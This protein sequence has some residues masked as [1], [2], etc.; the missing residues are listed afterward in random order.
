[1][2]LKAKKPSLA[3]KASMLYLQGPDAGQVQFTIQCNN[4][5]KGS[6]ISMSADAT[7]PV[8]PI[9]LQ[10][11]VISTYPAF[12]T[13]IIADVPAGY[14]SNINFELYCVGKPPAGSTVSLVAGY[15]SQQSSDS[16]LH[17]GPVK[18]IVVAEVTITN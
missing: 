9:A 14:K 10:P 2:A 12:A 17:A 6:T 8:P 18:I 16:T 7:G 15:T 4:I 3:W 13:G 5:P 11:T 1:M